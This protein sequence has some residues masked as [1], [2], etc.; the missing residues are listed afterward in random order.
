V[1]ALVLAGG[2]V[3]PT[4]RL[5]TRAGEA[6]L[7]VAADGG[8]RHATTLG[9]RPDLLVGDLD[10]VGPDARERWP[11]LPVERH[12]TDKDALD[13]ELAIEAARARGA[14]EIRVMGA[15]GGRF[16][17]T[18]AT[19]AIA[20]RYAEQGVRIA[21]LDGIHDA[22][23]L[24]AG[25]RFEGPLPEGTTFSL[26]A[27]SDEARVDVAGA[28]YEL[29]GARLPRGLGLGLSNRA[30]GGPTVRVRAGTVLLIVEWDA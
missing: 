27:V 19:A 30:A 26:L 15:F 21:L 8:L 17:Q 24:A 20:A 7:V 28:A 5:R 6:A 9:V 13:L 10:S 2:P 1:I 16:D 29:A 25:D 14:D 18:L 23:P 22:Y 4:A 3:R 11:D 12:P